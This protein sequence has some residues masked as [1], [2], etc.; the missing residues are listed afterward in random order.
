MAWWEHAYPGGPMVGPALPRNLYPPDAAGYEPSP[1]GPDALAWK[2]SLARGGRWAW[3]PDAWDDTYSNVFAHGKVSGNVGESGVAGFQRQMRIDPAYGWVGTKTYNALRSALIPEPLP[4]AGEP[5]I[6]SVA[7]DLFEQAWDQFHEPSDQDKLEQVMR[8]M[9][10]YMRRSI[11]NRVNWHYVQQRPMTSLG[12]NPDGTVY[13]DCSEGATAIYYW[14]AKMSN[15]NVPDPNGNDFNGIGNTSTLWAFNAGRRA[16]PWY[17]VGDL[18]LYWAN[19]GHVTVCSRPGTATGSRWWSNGSEG[20]PY[21]EP[22][23]YRGDLRGVVR[24]IKLAA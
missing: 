6:D 5:L 22:L 10:D 12:D 23:W 1:D 2:R 7:I 15:Y 18:A 14:A 17:E 4:H 16:G 8:L 9:Q 3:T 20:G 11:A 24:P 21:E 13:S 19:N